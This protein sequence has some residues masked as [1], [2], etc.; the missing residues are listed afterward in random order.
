M[1]VLCFS[2]LY[3]HAAVPQHGVFVEN[4]LRRLVETGQVEA[5]VIAPVPWFPFK[6][7]AF[8]QY[9][10]HAKAPK[11][12]V[13]HGI[14][15][16]HP[17]YTVLPKIG[18][19]ITPT[20]LARAAVRCALDV[21]AGGFEC[22]LI[23]AHYFY[24][25]GVAA[26]AVA[27][28][29]GKPFM[30]T[31]RGTDINLIP[32]YPYA[33]KKVLGVAQ[34]ADALGAVC[35][36]LSDEMVSLGMDTSKLHV[37][38]NGVDLDLFAPK[39]RDASRHEWGVDGPVLVSVGGLN[40]RKGHHLTIEA[41]LGLPDFTFL[42]AGD[43]ENRS[44]LEA[45]AKGLGVAD[46]VRF[47]GP[48]AQDRL[49]SLF[50]A[51]DI[52]ILASSREGWANVLLEAMACGTPVL[53]TDVWGTPEVVAAPEAGRLLEARS[54]DAIVR[55]VNALWPDLP[56]RGATRHY[57]EQFSWAETTQRQIDIFSS[58]LGNS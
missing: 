39:D 45:L 8:G 36:A 55:G 20:T 26:A 11:V 44:K 16:H 54:S 17:R 51:A 35:Q 42:L 56:D 25:D 18:M 52:S 21:K 5:K 43:G 15:V 19:N 28:A 46:R 12:E 50:S 29:L 57:A 9:A 31:A 10:M 3:P 30:V 34:S 47:L 22:D 14:E 23:D 40:E 37:L 33:R 24:P 38:R 13:R 2:T 58:I 1:K 27:K 6:H 7:S 53:A 4:R 48:V 32:Q 41:M 49:A